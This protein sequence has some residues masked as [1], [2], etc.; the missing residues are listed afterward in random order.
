MMKLA[1]SWISCC[2]TAAESRRYRLPG[3][4]LFLLD[5]IIYGRQRHTIK[6]GSIM[7]RNGDE[8]R[9]HL[10]VISNIE[11]GTFC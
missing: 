8:I 3:L 1:G 6:Y 5:T 9:L 11:A 7:A 2:R 4:L 10:S